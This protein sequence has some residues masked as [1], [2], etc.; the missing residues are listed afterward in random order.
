MQAASAA[1]KVVV[2]DASV[3]INFLIIER[4]DLLETRPG[5]RFVLPQEVDAEIRRPEQRRQLDK[6]PAF[7]SLSIEPSTEPAEIALA[8]A[9]RLVLDRGES[10]CLAMA[11]HRGWSVACDERGRFSR[12]AE[13]RLG[14][15]RHLNTSG[16]LV[17][18]IREG[19]LNVSRADELKAI[20]E[21]NRFRMP[22]RSF[23][24]V[25]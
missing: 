24:E 2:V 13:E 3:L 10:A 4:L 11:Q 14:P 16:L 17:R 8:A 12:L 19:H 9:L 25:I 22:L 18:S 23:A 1:S 5:L 20:L 21:A 15:G 7:R 6:A